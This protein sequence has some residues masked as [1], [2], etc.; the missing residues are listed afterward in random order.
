MHISFEKARPPS[1]T[2]V[3]VRIGGRLPA[4]GMV[5][6]VAPLVQAMNNRMYRLGLAT[7]GIGL[8]SLALDTA[9]SFPVVCIWCF[10]QVYTTSIY[11]LGLYIIT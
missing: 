3:G 4:G 7:A 8:F 10:L 5:G 1:R 11:S 2:S 9:D 6:R